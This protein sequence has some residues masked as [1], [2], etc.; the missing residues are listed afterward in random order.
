MVSL[1]VFIFSI[2]LTIILTVNF[3]MPLIS[4]LQGFFCPAPACPE[5]SYSQPEPESLDE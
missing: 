5:C 3:Y 1:S 2:L 4:M